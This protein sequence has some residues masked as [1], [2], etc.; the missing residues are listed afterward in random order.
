MCHGAL[1]I[2]VGHMLKFVRGSG[3]GERM[4]QGHPSIEL[5]LNGW[6]ARSGKRYLSQL[7]RDTVVMAFLC[8]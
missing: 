1:G 2:E 4:K 8:E 5:R 3:I 6:C 7:L